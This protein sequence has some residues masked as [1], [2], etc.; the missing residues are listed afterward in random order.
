LLALVLFVADL[1][2]PAHGILS[3]AGVFALVLAMAFLI[4]TGPI[5]VGVNPWVSV[6]TALLTLAFFGLFIRK[7]PAARRRRVF[8]GG[9]EHRGL[10]GRGGGP[11]PE[12]LVF[13]AGALWKAVASPST[14]HAGSPVRVVGRKG[15]QLE[16]VAGENGEMKEKK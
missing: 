13:V 7:V 14:I 6:V 15:L 9:R 5:G 8:V 2:A 11:G 3:V 1:K 4:N 10:G 12:G 16:V